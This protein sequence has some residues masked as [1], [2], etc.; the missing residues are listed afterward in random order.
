MQ[1]FMAILFEE[2]F[3]AAVEYYRHIIELLTWG[4]TVWRDVPSQ[5]RGAIFKDTFLRG[6][7]NMYIDALIGVMSSVQISHINQH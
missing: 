6:V 3:T 1:A 7:R 2:N 5:D 4:R